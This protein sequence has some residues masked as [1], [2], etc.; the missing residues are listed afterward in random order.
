M[1]TTTLFLRFVIAVPLIQVY[2]MEDHGQFHFQYCF[3]SLGM[4][5]G[6]IT[7]GNIFSSIGSFSNS[8]NT[9]GAHRARLRSS[10]AFRADPLAI[11]E[12]SSN[13][14][15]VELNQEMIVTGIST[16]GFKGEWVTKFKLMALIKNRDSYIYFRGAYDSMTEKEFEGNTDGINIKLNEVPFPLQTSEVIVFP[17]QWH[18]NI[19]VRLELYGCKPGYHFSVWLT[20]LDEIF[21]LSYMDREDYGTKL[22]EEKVLSGINTYLEDIPGFLSAELDKFRFDIFINSLL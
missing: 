2:L 16:Q 3:K 9:F 14:I 13:F 12:N 20:V 7:D 4:E 22:L 18:K 11:N 8:T 10:S 19:A 17:T 1:S 6:Q 15:G 5:S 21:R